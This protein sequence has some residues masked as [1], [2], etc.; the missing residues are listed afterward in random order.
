MDAELTLG[1]QNLFPRNA[2]CANCPQTALVTVWLYFLLAHLP[3]MLGRGHTLASFR[4]SGHP[5]PRFPPVASALA[6]RKMEWPSQE[7]GVCVGLH[8]DSTTPAQPWPPG[9]QCLS[10]HSWGHQS[11]GNHV[12]T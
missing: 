11:C 10:A 7:V 1:A 12:H 9:K 6:A 2:L 8:L 5:H 3:L 4:L